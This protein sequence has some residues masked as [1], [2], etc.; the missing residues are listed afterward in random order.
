MK[1]W[2]HAFQACDAGSIPAADSP[3]FAFVGFGW[4]ASAVTR[5]AA[6][7]TPRRA[8]R[9]QANLVE[10]LEWGPSPAAALRDL[11]GQILG[12]RG[13]ASLDHALEGWCDTVRLSR[14]GE[15]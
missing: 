8:R 15:P 11:V 5:S 13:A 4:Q 10:Q 6:P 1:A 2:N 7:E 14:L 3:A 9:N 12:R